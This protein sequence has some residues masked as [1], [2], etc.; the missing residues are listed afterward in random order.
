MEFQQSCVKIQQ[1]IFGDNMQVVQLLGPVHTGHGGTFAC[2]SFDV[3]GCAVWTLQC[4]FL[5]LR[6]PLA[7]TASCVNGALRFQGTSRSTSTK[8]F[9]KAQFS[10][11]SGRTDVRVAK[12]LVEIPPGVVP[13]TQF[14][15][16]KFRPFFDQKWKRGPK[17]P[18][19][20]PL[21]FFSH[22]FG[23]TES[24][25]PEHKDSV[26]AKISAFFKSWI[27]HVKRTK[28]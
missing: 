27:W 22:I 23:C 25:R 11:F 10:I 20:F 14:V 5:F 8:L 26:W 6:A 17:C 13:C 1:W 19:L 3:A 21:N 24:I 4:R 18:E 15:L 28:H 7:S 16:Q 9:T 12:I 2:K